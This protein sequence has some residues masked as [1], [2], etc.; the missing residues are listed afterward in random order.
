[1]KDK[2]RKITLIVLICIAMIGSFL[3]LTVFSFVKSSDAFTESFNGSIERAYEQSDKSQSLEELKETS[4]KGMDVLQ[5]LIA[6]TIVLQII[7]LICAIKGPNKNRIALIYLSILNLILS[8]SL[9]SIAILVISCLKS[10][11]V[12]YEKPIPPEVENVSTFKL[13]VYIISFLAIWVLIYNGIL[14]KV[15]PQIKEWGVEHDLLFEVLFFLIL[16]AMVLIL[17]RKELIRDFKLLIHNFATYHNIVAR[18]FFWIML[19][20]LVSGIIVNQI[21]KEQSENQALLNEMPLWFMIIFGTIIGPM[22][23]EGIYRGLLGKIIKNKIAFVILSAAMFGA[24]HVVTFTSFP[25][26]PMQYFFLIQ[27]GVMGIVLATNYARTKNIFSSY[28]I[29]MFMNGTAT[30]LTALI[31]L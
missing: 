15:F 14:I 13:P 9:I 29:H 27:Y 3:T 30:V 24:M 18:G 8:F 19:L 11:D 7:I 2:T 22:V 31:L 23:E 21:V 12:P 26:S 1:M 25:K 10:K 4:E 20:N 16:F 5:K 28:L 17:L 6:L